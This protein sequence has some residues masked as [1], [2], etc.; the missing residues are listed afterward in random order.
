MVGNREI[1]DENSG[2]SDNLVK[3]VRTVI[4][5]YLPPECISISFRASEISISVSLD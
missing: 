2:I 4:K 5:S 1:F 3:P